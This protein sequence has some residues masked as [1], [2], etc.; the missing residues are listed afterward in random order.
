MPK[1]QQTVVQA[2][3]TSAGRRKSAAGARTARKTCACRTGQGGEQTQLAQPRSTRGS[4][5]LSKAG[6]DEL[7]QSLAGMAKQMQGLSRLAVRQYTPVVEN[8]IHIRSRDINHIELTL[9]RLL[10]FCWDDAGLALFKRLCRYYWDIDPAATARQIQ[11]YRELWDSDE[12]A[13]AGETRS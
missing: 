4:S 7:L 11:A 12:Q 2:T 3:T 13:A 5:G 1:K 6:Y 9:D 10:D 8:I